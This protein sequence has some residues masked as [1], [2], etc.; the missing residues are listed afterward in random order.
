MTTF[1]GPYVQAAA[2]N[3][4]RAELVVDQV[5]PGGSLSSGD[6]YVDLPWTLRL[7]KNPAD[8]SGSS[9]N[10]TSD[11]SVSGTDSASGSKAWSLGS[12]GAVVT[13]ASGTVRVS[14]TYAKQSKSFSASVD[15]RVL[16]GVPSVSGTVT[17]PARPVDPPAPP[18]GFTVTRVSDSRQ[19]LAWSV[20]STTSAPVETVEIRRMDQVNA[21][22][23]IAELTGPATA[24]ADTSTRADRHYRY[25]VRTRNSAGWSV[26]VYFEIDTTPARMGTPSAAKNSAGDIVVARGS[27]SPVAATWEVKEASG[28]TL[29]TDIPASQETWRHPSPSPSQAWSYV[30]RAVSASPAL[31]GEYSSASTPVALV[32]APNAPTALL[33]YVLDPSETNE[34]TWRHNAVDTTPQTAWTLRWR[35]YG[36]PAWTTIDK[37]TSAE[38]SYELPADTW[39]LTTAGVEW[40]VSTWG[41][42]TTGGRDG[43]GASPWSSSRATVTSGRPTVGIVAP[44]LLVTASRVTVEWTF[45]DPEATNQ[46]KWRVVLKDDDAGNRIWEEKGGPGATSSVTMSTP[47]PDGSTWTV[48]VTAWDGHGLEATDSRTFTVEWATPPVPTGEVVWHKD[49]GY[50]VVTPSAPAPGPDEVAVD[51]FQ[52]YRADPVAG[53]YALVADDLAEGESVTDRTPPTGTVV[54]YRVVAVSALPSTALSGDLVVETDTRWVFFNWGPGFSRTVRLWGNLSAARGSSRAKALHHMAGRDLPVE[55]GGTARTRTYTLTATLFGRQ[56]LRQAPDG[57]STWPDVEEL[58]DAS[59]PVLLRDPEGTRMFC[60]TGDPALSDH[61]KLHPT[62]TIPVTQV[63]HREEVVQL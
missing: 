29:A 30:T 1:T 34:L 44:E 53:G 37:T 46:A 25:A 55:R 4:V 41:Q 17:I 33:P 23:Q 3:R 18:T 14:L 63:D 13:I 15:H 7:R 9:C 32:A 26:F 11:W 48:E 45:F 58:G 57:S 28:A 5:F 12:P 56:A 61:L 43:T 50:A 59:A 60:S 27:I 10:D 22:A 21:Y 8:A 2:Y 54:T 20:T 51:H 47:L 52:V 31:P 62:V 36:Q 24:Y 39:P 16:S 38:S 42:A 40:Q 6:T 19:N 49:D 35:Q